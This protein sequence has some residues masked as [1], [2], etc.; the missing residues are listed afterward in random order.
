MN[1]KENKDLEDVGALGSSPV[2]G[3][4]QLLQGTGVADEFVQQTHN[5]VELGP[6]TALALPAVH[7]QVVE[8]LR[9]VHGAG[10]PVTLLHRLDDLEQQQ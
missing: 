6:V 1:R 8:R 10:Q 5:L 4:E 9:A 2:G 7:H 3:V